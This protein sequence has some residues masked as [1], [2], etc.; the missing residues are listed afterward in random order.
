MFVSQKSIGECGGRVTVTRT[1]S[2]DV[3]ADEFDAVN[4][5]IVVVISFHFFVQKKKNN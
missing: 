4:N 5:F 2:V 3:V 1:T